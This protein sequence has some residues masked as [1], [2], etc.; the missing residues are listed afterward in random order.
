MSGEAGTVCMPV[1]KIQSATTAA[2]ALLLV[3]LRAA[4]ALA[5]LPPQYTTWAEYSA[6]AALSE[7]PHLIGVVER[8]ERAGPGK[9]MLR[10]ERCRVEVSIERRAPVSPG[11]AT[12][13]GGSS[14]VGIKVG[15]PRCD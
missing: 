7:I 6:V 1:S 5:E 3:A 10:G 4:P 2:A 15:E 13:V 11:G 9:Y 12:M 14:I 8:I